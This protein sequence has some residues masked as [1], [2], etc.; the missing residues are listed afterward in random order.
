MSMFKRIILA[1]ALAAVS[2]FAAWDLFPVLENHMG[3][4]RLGATYQTHEYEDR[5]YQII[6]LNA[7]VRYTVIQD[8][9]LALSIPYWLLTYVDGERYFGNEFGNL[10]FS[11]R[12]QFIP[13]MNAFV[14]VSVPVR[15][16]DD[17]TWGFDLGLQFSRRVNQLIN[18]GSQLGTSYA[19]WRDYDGVP[20]DVYGS[21]CLRFAVTPQ[22]TPYYGTSFNFSLGEFTD[23]GYEYSHGGGDLYLAPYV[24]AIYDFNDF[25]SVDAWGKIGRYVTIDDYPDFIFVAGLSILVNF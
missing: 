7:G 20:I 17:G 19:I 10:N 5:D 21:A 22:F 1:C 25:V 16:I 23:G 8:L 6:K 11:T 24:G 18:F 15:D 13:V 2:S 12:Y 4:A 3:Q 14:D 9:E